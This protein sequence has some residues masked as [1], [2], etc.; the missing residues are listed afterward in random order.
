VL[1]EPLGAMWQQDAWAP[2][3]AETQRAFEESPLAAADLSGY[4]RVV[5]HD[6]LVARHLDVRRSP[7]WAVDDALFLG[8][9]PPP[10]PVK[11]LF[12]GESTYD[13]EHVIIDAKH[14]YEL[15]HYAYGLTGERLEEVLEA[16]NVGVVVHPLRGRLTFPPEAALHLA[17]GHLLITNPLV[18]PRGLEPG[19]DHLVI[20][21]LDQLLHFLHELRKRPKVF[22]HVRLRGRLR[23]EELRASRVWPRLLADLGPDLEAFG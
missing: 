12:L 1:T 20:F 16:T 2:D 19:L 7:P 11:P 9:R 8:H 17:A 10:D 22:E 15:S 3:A 13:R 4:A 21:E 5:A 6:P 14:H 23:A 18:P